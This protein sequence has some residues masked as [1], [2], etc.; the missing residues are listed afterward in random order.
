M[1]TTVTRLIRF[2]QRHIPLDRY[3]LLEE[4]GHGAHTRVLKAFDTAAHG[5]VALKILRERC[6]KHEERRA[7]LAK[8]GASLARIHHANVVPVL[9]LAKAPEPFYAMPFLEGRLLSDYRRRG[10]APARALRVLGI[11]LADALGA[12]HSMGLVHCDFRP[13]NVMIVRKRPIV[14]DLGS[15]FDMTADRSGWGNLL[16][17]RF[18]YA[19]PEVIRGRP[20]TPATDLYALGLVLFELAAGRHPFACSDASETMR[21]QLSVTAPRLRDARPDLPADLESLV[22]ALLEKNPSRRPRSAFEVSSRVM[23]SNLTEAA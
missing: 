6:E 14:F 20:A 1:A 5:I 13:E 3:H 8:E 2:E 19:A 4:L 15:A 18:E 12:I 16:A 11:E 23:K 7:Q 22:S 17:T 10:P 21:R 9:D